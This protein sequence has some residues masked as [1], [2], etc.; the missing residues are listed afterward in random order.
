MTNQPPASRTGQKPTMASRLAAQLRQSILSGELAPG[1]KV[2]LDR[3]R[4]RYAVSLSPMREAIAR[5]VADGLVELEDQRGYRIT[6]VSAE[7]SAEIT[8]L[9][10]D[11]DPLALGYALAQAD[12]DWESEIVG[13]LHRLNQTRRDPNDPASLE[14]WQTA[15]SGF[16]RKLISRCDLPNLLQFCA[17]LRAQHDRYG[18]IFGSEG[19][20]DRDLAGEHQGLVDAALAGD[21]ARATGLL[22]VHIEND[23]RD[24]ALRI[25]DRQRQMADAT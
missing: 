6:P 5:L 10:A 9:R 7:N 4:Q 15:H 16:H 14:P 19:G 22:R 20:D 24:L 18:W 2:N 13:A 11:L 1:S 23:G 21:A 3:L 25:G 12:L 17:V 8:R